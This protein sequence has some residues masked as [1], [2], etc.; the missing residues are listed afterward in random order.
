MASHPDPLVALR[1][2][3]SSAPW[4]ARELIELADRLLSGVDPDQDRPLTDRTLHYYVASRV[5]RPPS[6]RGAGTGWGYPHLIELLAARLA[7]AAGDSLPVIATRRDEW[8]LD[9]LERQVADALGCAVG[10]PVDSTQA[11]D[12]GDIPVAW[13]DHQITPSVVLR[14]AVTHPLHDDPRR[15]G[16]LLDGLARE[17][18]L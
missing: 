4:R 7:R 18:D 13:R 8:A 1:R 6:G 17:V 10:A 9:A 2:H 12:S 5:V 11:D 3:A 15:L 14:L 16:V